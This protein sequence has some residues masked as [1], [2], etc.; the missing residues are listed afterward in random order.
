[1]KRFSPAFRGAALPAAVA[2]A[3]CI[4]PAGAATLTVPLTVNPQESQ[5]TT[6]LCVQDDCSSDT[7]P[8]AGEIRLRIGC[9]SPP[10]EAALADLR[11]AATT[12]HVANIDL[13]FGGRV[14]ALLE[15]LVI[16]HAI[17]G[18]ARPPAPVTNGQVMFEGVPTLLAGTLAYDAAGLACVVVQLAGLQ[19]VDSLDLSDRSTNTIR[20]LAATLEVSG[21][22]VTL[23]GSFDFQEFIDAEQP[24]LGHVE[25]RAEF[26]ASGEL[27]PQLAIAAE[28]NGLHL[29]WCRVFEGF[30]LEHADS[31]RGEWTTVN[32]PPEA[33]GDEWRTTIP[34]DV[35]AGYYRLRS[36]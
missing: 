35:A 26:V 17:P 19:C 9:E 32:A 2:L 28:G 3:G 1:M 14:S 8:L 5:L 21:G 20:E 31:L 29:R 10:R 22:R 34:A 18:D 30:V 7:H 16:R 13:G 12:N 6:G 4:I 24:A 36:N 15:G 11:L 27:R 25:G 23:R 33:D